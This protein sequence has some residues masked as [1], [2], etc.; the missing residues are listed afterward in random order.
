M[1]IG[2]KIDEKTRLRR[3]ANFT[4]PYILPSGWREALKYACGHP[5]SNEILNV[6]IWIAF[7]MKPYTL[8]VFEHQLNFADVFL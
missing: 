6:H 4:G 8:I 3:L 5:L 7:E 2:R 1:Q